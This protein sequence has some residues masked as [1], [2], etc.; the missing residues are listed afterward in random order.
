MEPVGNQKGSLRSA[1]SNI[2]FLRHLTRRPRSGWQQE[3]SGW[4]L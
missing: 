4:L 1:A 3:G 2:T